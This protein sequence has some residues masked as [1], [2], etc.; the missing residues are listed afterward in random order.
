MKSLSRLMGRLE[1]LEAATESLRAGR[2]SPICSLLREAAQC[3]AAREGISEEEAMPPTIRNRLAIR[4][5]GGDEPGMLI[6]E[7]QFIT[8]GIKDEE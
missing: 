7:L 4:E 1:K 3:I 5:S 8:D 2:Q 6:E